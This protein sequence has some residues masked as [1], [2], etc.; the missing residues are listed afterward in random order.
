[1]ALGPQFPQGAVILMSTD[2][3]FHI[4]RWQDV[5]A[6]ILAALDEVAISR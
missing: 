6:R 2:A 1:V 4:Y 3:T 5:E